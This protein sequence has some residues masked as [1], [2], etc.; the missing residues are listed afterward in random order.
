M[1]NRSWGKGYHTGHEKGITKGIA[2]ALTVV[3]AEKAIAAIS[4]Y[5]STRKTKAEKITAK[6]R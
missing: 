2:I 1:G 4:D 3:L 5:I 6:E